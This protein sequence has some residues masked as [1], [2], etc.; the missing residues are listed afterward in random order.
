[1]DFIRLLF[2]AVVILRL[3]VEQLSTKPVVQAVVHFVLKTL[4]LQLKADALVLRQRKQQQ[5]YNRW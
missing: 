1:M 2:G 5:V 3:K 4:L